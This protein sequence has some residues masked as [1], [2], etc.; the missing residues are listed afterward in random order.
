LRIVT[1]R[2]AEP[3]AHEVDVALNG[4]GRDLEFRR[5]LLAVRKVV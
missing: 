3:V 1:D 2:Q 5:D 4:L